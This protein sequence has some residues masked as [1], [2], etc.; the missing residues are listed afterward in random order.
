[1]PLL[2][3]DEDVRVG[4]AITPEALCIQLMLL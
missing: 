2:Q 4:G 1:M 3:R